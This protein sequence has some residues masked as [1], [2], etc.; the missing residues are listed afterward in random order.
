M[1]LTRVLLDAQSLSSVASATGSG[2]Y[3]RSLMSALALRN[4][5]ALSALCRPEVHF[6]ND[7]EAVPVRRLMTHPRALLMENALR[8]PFDVREH[9]PEGGVFHNPLYHA[10][11]G[12]RSPWVQTLHDVIPLVMD[13]PDLV[14]LR[15]RWK[16]FGPRYR[17]ASAVIAISKHA[18]DDGIRWLG[19]NPDQVYVAPHGVDPAFSVGGGAID[20]HTAAGEPYLLVVS[21]YSPRKGFAE[22]FGVMDALV[23]AGYPHRLV[24]A[25]QVH[26]WGRR[27]LAALH[28]RSRHPERIELRGF[29]N[30]LVGLYRGAS[31]FL[32]TSRY[33]GFGLPPLEAMACGVPVVAFSNSAVT[34]VVGD[35]GLLVTDGDV[36]AMTTEVRRLLDTPSLWAELRER[37]LAHVR[38]FTWARSA[39]LHAEVYRSVAA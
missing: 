39:A 17:E 14:E 1:T 3:V 13:S 5:I 25:G 32:M 21:E 19:L 6:G 4:D 24:V 31:V 35:G 11:A 36:P 10:P 9:R 8:L 2:T 16:R 22:A 7:I 33:E 20:N 37:G 29:V 18:A 30:D 38:P 23:D 28:A 15:A 34:E 26:E 27:D 12:I